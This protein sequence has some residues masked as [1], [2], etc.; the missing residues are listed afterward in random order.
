MS[1]NCFLVVA[2]VFVEEL[3]I[4][5]AAVICLVPGECNPY[6]KACAEIV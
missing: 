2:T 3:F 5:T 4:N 6:A 1:A